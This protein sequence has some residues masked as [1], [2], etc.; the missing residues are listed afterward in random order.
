MKKKKI[1]VE[2]QNKQLDALEDLLYAE[3]NEKE[4]AGAIKQVKQ[5]WQ[6]LVEA[7]DKE[8]VK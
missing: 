2:I 5:L 3:L 1:S 8:K 7:F 6:S 4:K